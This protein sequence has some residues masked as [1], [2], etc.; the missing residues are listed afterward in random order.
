MKRFLFSLYMV[1]F[2]AT[3]T[4]VGALVLLSVFDRLVNETRFPGHTYANF[5][6][7]ESCN[8]YMGHYYY[9]SLLSFLMYLIT[10]L[11]IAGSVVLACNV[12]IRRRLARRRADGSPP[13]RPSVSAAQGTKSW[14]RWMKRFVSALLLTVLNAMS[15]F[16]GAILL[17][18]LLERLP[19]ELPYSVHKFVSLVLHFT[20]NGDM[21]NIEGLLDT[22]FL[23]HLIVSLVF[24]S[25]A[26]IVCNI[27]I[28]RRLAKRRAG[29]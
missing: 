25:A 24:T 29:G 17:A 3:V 6:F 12:A 26:V 4:L 23:L 14:R 16:V 21:D 28:R 10:A 11:L 2:N 7:P 22:L 13:P 1:V 5:L 8:P 18:A 9:M 15:T 20:C 19:M 27:A